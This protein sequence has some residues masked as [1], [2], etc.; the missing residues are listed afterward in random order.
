[1]SKML[2]L[3]ALAAVAIAQPAF[4]APGLGEQVYGATVEKGVTE[5]ETR[6][7]RL[8]GGADAGEDKLVLEVAH[9][10]TDHLYAAGLAEFEREPGGDRRLE[11][12]GMETVVNVGRIPS[13]GLDVGVY[14]EY[15]AVRDGPD[16]VE[17]KLLLQHKRGAFDGRLNLIAEKTLSGGNPV[18]FGYAASAD[19]EVVDEVRVG[20]AA[21]G[22][23]GPAKDF[24]LGGEHFAGPIVKAEL[25]D[26]GPGELEV[27]TGY[28]FALGDARDNAKGQLRLLLEYEFR[29]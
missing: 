15:E 6:Y 22:D 8:T 19:W 12:L 3:A 24:R 29:F 7:G 17:T 16:H 10:F 27:E 1:M 2:P 28:L 25:E 21:F 5:V 18:G 11:A 4:A 13:L 23:F 14:G 26:L 20:A 9:G